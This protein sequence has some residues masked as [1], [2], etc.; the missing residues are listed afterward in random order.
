MKNLWTPWRMAYVGGREQ[1]KPGCIFEAAPGKSADKENLLLYR[2]RLVVVMLNRYPYA[3]GHLL[4][5]PV[6]H[7]AGIEEMT[8]DECQALMAMIQKTVAVLDV[9]FKPHGFNIG[10]NQGEAA[11]AGLADHLHFHVVPRWSG[12]HNYLAVLAEIRTIPDHIENTF[13][14]LLPDFRRLME[15]ENHRGQR[16]KED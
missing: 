14:L 2:D 8:G 16:R 6:R 9:H 15:E 4:V 1:K 12:D 13:D 11:G 3:N 5:G 10:L 7:L